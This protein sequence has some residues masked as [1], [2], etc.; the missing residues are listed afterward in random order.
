MMNN[1][2][3]DDGKRILLGLFN[4]KENAEEAYH[5]LRNAGYSAEEI[6]VVMDHE[7]REKYYG[8]LEVHEDSVGSKA[9]EGA[10]AGGTIGGVVGGIGAALASLGSNLII[11]G[12]G[13]VV[14]GPLAAGLAGFGAGGLTG[15][16]IG[17]LIGA[18]TPKEKAEVYH[19]GLRNGKILISVHP[20]S[21]EDIINFR[22]SWD[23]YNAEDIYPDVTA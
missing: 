11:P 14:L 21:N 16:I 22:N 3:D 18:G 6:N 12:L 10:G 9:L 4:D 17:A 20:H 8:D 19:H 15:G 23:E 1:D 2:L 5:D 7:T 13:F